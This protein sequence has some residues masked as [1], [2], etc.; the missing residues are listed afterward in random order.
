MSLQ[1]FPATFFTYSTDYPNSGQRIQ[2]GNSWQFDSPSPA[3]DQR[4]FRLKL[5]GMTYFLNANGTINSS[6]NPGRNLALLEQFYTQ[7]RLATRFTLNHPVYGARTCKFNQPLKIPNPLP[8]GS[9]VF[10]EF[11]V[12]LI[13]L[14]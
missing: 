14:P 5:Q 6:I 7:H 9:G 11:E 12:E 3:P 4:I 10:P 1:T 2:L 13:E 8:G